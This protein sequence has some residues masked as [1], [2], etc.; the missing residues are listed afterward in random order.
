MYKATRWYVASQ[1]K[2][3]KDIFYEAPN[4]LELAPPEPD[5]EVVA[6]METVSARL[7]VC[8]SDFKEKEQKLNRELQKA[9][10]EIVTLETKLREANRKIRMLEAQVVCPSKVRRLV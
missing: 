10:G 6:Y 9:G 3:N 7:E 8:Y 2:R 1:M 4:I 5:P